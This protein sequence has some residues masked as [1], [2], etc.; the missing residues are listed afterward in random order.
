M[1]DMGTTQ[2]QAAVTGAAWLVQL[3]FASGVQRFTTFPHTLHVDGYN[4]LGLGAV[5]SVGSV[6]ESEEVQADAL[7]ISLSVVDTALIALSLGNVEGYRGRRADV[8][9]QLLT[10]T[11]QPIGPKRRRWSGLMDR[12]EIRRASGDD[13]STGTIEL[14]CVR[15]GIARM[16]NA[17]GLR[18]THEQQLRRFP[19]DTGL[20]YVRTLIEQPALWLSRAFLQR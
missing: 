20:R 3:D 9:L 14:R 19:G 5:T 10:A 13:G 8:Y 1:I 16:R 2:H 17:Q 4:W 15:A 7:V 6:T 12:V 18:L 11:Y